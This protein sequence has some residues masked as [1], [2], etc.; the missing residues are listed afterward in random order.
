MT[1]MNNKQTEQYLKKNRPNKVLPIINTCFG[2]VFLIGSI[3]CKIRYNDIYPT[4]WFILFNVLVMLFPLASWYNS[5]FSKKINL[6]RIE[7]YDLETKEIVSYIKR[8]QSYKGVE[9]NKDK[10]LVATFE[11][12]DEIIDKQPNYMLEHYSLGLPKENPIIITFGIGFAGIELKAFNKEIIGLCGVLPRSVW[13][14]KKLKVPTPKKGKVLL[15]PVGF[16]FAEKQVIQAMKNM[17]TYY[18]NKTGWVVIG[19]YKDT[20]LNHTIEI[21]HDTYIVIRNNEVIAIWFKIDAGLA[22]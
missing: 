18:D 17:E 15:E 5:Y 8:L 21:M 14:K 19:E 13:R 10:K 11:Y 2:G 12:T 6:R 16:N 1:N 3:Y 20:P 9:L 4:L 22:I 7:N